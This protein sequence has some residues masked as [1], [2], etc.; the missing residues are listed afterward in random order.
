MQD[1]RSAAAEVG[2]NA[3]PHSHAPSEHAAVPVCRV[4]LRRQESQTSRATHSTQAPQVT[5]PHPGA[6]HDGRTVRLLEEENDHDPVEV[7]RNKA[8]ADVPA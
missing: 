6:E 2:K 5:Y 8:A 3:T 7:G 1:M 4:R